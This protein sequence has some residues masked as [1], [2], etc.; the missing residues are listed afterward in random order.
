MDRQ[1]RELAVIKN[2]VFLVSHI[3]LFFQ[4]KDN[5][6]CFI[7]MKTCHGLLVNKDGLKF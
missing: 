5:L 6:F 2:S 3:D 7:P 4:K 1:I